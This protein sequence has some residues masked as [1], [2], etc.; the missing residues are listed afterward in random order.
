LQRRLDWLHAVCA[1]AAISASA[2]ADPVTPPGSAGVPAAGRWV[3]R[4][5]LEWP[6]IKPRQ[7]W[8]TATSVPGYEILRLPTFREEAAWWGTGRLELRSYAQVMPGELDCRLTCQPSLEQSGGLDVR[9][10]LG[11]AGAVPNTF[12]S[13]RREHAITPAR[14]DSRWALG[15][16][17]LLDL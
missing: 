12:L 15:F 13:L 8:F 1:S 9:L 10:D 6:S 5:E 17:G 7:R 2:A 3:Q 11:G 16:G 4:L 14:A